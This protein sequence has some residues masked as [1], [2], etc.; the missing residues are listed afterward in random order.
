LYTAKPVTSIDLHHH[1]DRL[2]TQK[3]QPDE[4][5]AIYS[6][7]AATIQ[8]PSEICQL[9]TV[10]SESHGGLF[11]LALGLVHPRKEIQYKTVELLDR[12]MQ[13]E[14]GQPFWESLN[15]F[16][17]LAFYRLKRELESVLRSASDSEAERGPLMEEASIEAA[18]RAAQLDADTADQQARFGPVSPR[19]EV[20]N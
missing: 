12:I 15:R 7:F 11:F 19:D 18:F 4:A 17:K 6:A 2:R 14:A 20:F 9:L 8:T 13:H 5:A 3:L 1:H 10:T 16:S